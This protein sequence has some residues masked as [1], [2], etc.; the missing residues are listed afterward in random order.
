MGKKNKL[1]KKK[2]NK[3]KN[4]INSESKGTP[5]SIKPSEANEDR[6]KLSKEFLHKKKE[7]KRKVKRLNKKRNK[8][9]E[10]KNYDLD[11]MLQDYLFSSQDELD[12]LPHDKFITYTEPKT[13]EENKEYIPLLISE[14]D[15]ILDLI[16][17]RDVFH[18]KNDAIEKII[19]NN[20]KKLLIYIITKCDLVSDEYLRKIKAYL[21]KLNNNNPIIV[22][23][24]LIRE[25]VQLLLDELKKYVEIAKN[26]NENK[27][28]IKIGIIGAPNVG[29]NSL[30][31]SLELLIDSNCTEKYIY[32]NEEKDFCINSIPGILFDEEE[33]NNLLISKKYKNVDDISQPENLIAN[34]LPIV[35]QENLKNT[36]ELEKVPENLTDFIELIK[37]KYDYSKDILAIRKILN[38]IIT[39]KIRYEVSV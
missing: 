21:E 7:L 33:K 1:K 8:M 28:C 26:K 15:I 13:P 19:N 3:N 36:Y 29:K 30:I 6:K 5:S 24:S 14:S 12:K 11:F 4:H 32:F 31:Q 20:S 18:S 22:I 16:D 9:K 35:G 25:K 17:A 10:F 39:G 2:K 37:A 27:S 23:S 38:D 34:L